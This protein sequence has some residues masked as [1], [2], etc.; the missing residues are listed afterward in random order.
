[1]PRPWPTDPPTAAHR[2]AYAGAATTSFW[3]DDLP[4]RAGDPPLSGSTTADLCIVGGGFTGL[5]AALHAKAD[6]PSRDV[7]LLEADRIGAGASGRNGGFAVAS[8]THGLGNGLARFPAEM[9]ALERLALE[10]FAGIKD[11]LARHGIDAQLEET[12]E[13]LALLEPHEVEAAQQDAELAR[14]FGHD[15]E[16]LDAVAMRAEVDSPLFLGGVWDRTG[17]GVLH[18]GRLVAG[19]R[20]SALVAGVRLH[21]RTPALG[22]ERAGDAM[23]VRTPGGTVRARRTLLATSAYPPLLARLRHFVVPV[24]DYV[25]VTEPLSAEQK[26]SV[27]WRNRQGIGDGGNQFHY[28]R[29]TADDRILWG[30]Y[31]AVYRR[32]GPVG[33]QY[34]DHDPTFAAL[35]QHFFATFPQLEG[36]RFTH[37]WGGAIDTCSRFSVFFGTAH[38]GRVAYATGYTGL[39]VAATRFGARVGLDLLDGR[40]TEATRLRYVRRKP[41]PFPPEPLRS[42]VVALTQRGLAA[43]DRHEGRRGPWLRLLDRLGLGFDS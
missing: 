1:M 2:A 31:D 35:S 24:Y 10:N 43:A 23:D 34:D 36:V 28:Y 33:P 21:E 16:V 8:L 27:G 29:L 38:G 7:V 19:L 22:L 40:E 32:G 6:D 9:P 30:G 41:V 39:G 25:L 18:P 42:A 3:L 5:W 12:G 26:A 14:A 15:V 37:R 4:E 17:A 11:D 20:D 13:L